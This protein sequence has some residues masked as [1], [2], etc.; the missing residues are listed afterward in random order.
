MPTIS[1]ERPSSASVRP[2]TDPSPPKWRCQNA[3]DT[4]TEAGASGSGTVL[5]VDEPAAERGLHAERLEHAVRH[6]QH[7]D[8]LGIAQT[9]QRSSTASFQKPTSLERAV[10]V[11]IRDVLALG[12]TLLR[13]AANLEPSAECSRARGRPDRAAA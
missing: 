5:G 6:R 4:I 3:Y 1:Y 11:S 10:R 9:R 7:A 2:S 12:K 8:L 13:R